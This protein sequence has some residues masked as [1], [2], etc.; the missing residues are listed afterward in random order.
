MQGG[1]R[2]VRIRAHDGRVFI[3][4]LLCP[5]V[6]CAEPFEARSATL[7]ELEALVCDCGCAL[8]ITRVADLVDDRDETL[9]FVALG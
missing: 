5:D 8:R 9:L 7:A 2:S 1:A 6:S 4:E 3:A